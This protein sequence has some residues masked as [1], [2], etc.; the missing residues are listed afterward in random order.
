MDTDSDEEWSE[1][2]ERQAAKR[3]RALAGGLRL[4]KFQSSKSMSLDPMMSSGPPQGQT[5]HNREEEPLGVY[6]ASLQPSSGETVL[7]DHNEDKGKEP[8]LYPCSCKCSQSSGCKT[9][10]CECK[11][12]GGLC[13]TQCGCSSVK[14]NNREAVA[15]EE[16]QSFSLAY[17]IQ[18]E[19]AQA[20][21]SP[22]VD[23][24]C[25]RLHDQGAAGQLVQGGEPFIHVVTEEEH[26]T[27]R[28]DRDLA[29]H[30]A[31]LLESAWRD[32]LQ[33]TADLRGQDADAVEDA[34]T[35]KT[36][37]RPLQDIG[38]KVCPTFHL[39]Y[40]I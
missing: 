30:G 39:L 18:M 34:P 20:L 14:C 1:D 38:N 4:S 31:S 2:T 15:M 12:A 22:R 26:V 3:N 16:E 7:D 9:K 33:E 21:A 19:V 25:R 35:K 11:A 37:R 24:N 10:K 17:P 23:K 13:G 28:V 6:R 8:R 32:E 5:H 36:R 40:L 29:V 27:K